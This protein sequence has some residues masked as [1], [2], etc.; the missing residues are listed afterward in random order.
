MERVPE[1][2]LMLD[3]EQAK[4]YAA[5]DFSEPHGR[6][7]ALLRERLRDLPLAGT[8]ADLG[9]GPADIA[10]RFARAFPHWLVDGVD[11]SAAMLEAGRAIVTKEGLDARVRLHHARLPAPPL[12]ATR[13]DLVISNSLLHHLSMPAV[14]WSTVREWTALGGAAFVMDLFRPASVEEARSL[15]A[16]HSAGEPP[17]FQR[18]FYN[19]LLAA[20]RP[21]EVRKQ[22]ADAGL[23]A[24]SVETVSDRHLI[25]FG[26]RS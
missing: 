11:G 4:A 13:Y 16:K 18:D 6:F 20:Y 15:V 5:V 14:L 8:A 23:G 3:A 22:L 10:I 9:C 19:S 24:L 7:V 26:R 12:G 17:V 2:E 1:P 21:V 25:V